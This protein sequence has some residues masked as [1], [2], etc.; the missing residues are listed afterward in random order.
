MVRV[1][2][3]AAYL[4]AAGIVFALAWLPV[5]VTMQ[6]ILYEDFFYALKIADNFIETGEVTF[7]GTARTNA[8]ILQPMWTAL[9]VAARAVAGKELALHIMLTVGAVLHLAQ[10]YLVFSLVA[11]FCNRRVGH[12][13]AVF[14]ALNYRVIACNLCGLEPPL[15]AFFLLLIVWYLR[16]VPRPMTVARS[17]LLGL[18]LAL[19]IMSRFDQVLLAVAVLGLILLDHAAKTRPLRARLISAVT[20]G[21]TMAALLSPWFVWSLRH[22]GTVLPN[23]H[24]ALNLWRFRQF[25]LTGP[26]SEN[27]AVL[28]DKFAEA[29]WW[30][31]D[32]ANLLGVLPLVRPTDV[33]PAV[34]LVL[35]LAVIIMAVLWFSKRGV[36]LSLR[37]ML[38]LYAVIHL[39]YY[40]LFAFPEVRYLVPFGVVGIVLAAS[41]L[42][43]ASMR[44]RGV[45][46]PTTLG[47]VYAVLLTNSLI[48]GF[49]GW[50]KQ[51]GATTTHALHADLHTMA[52][53]VRENTPS[54]AVLGC[55]NA[56]IMGCFSGRTVVNLDGVVNDDVIE[57]MRDKELLRYLRRRGVTHLVDMH[58][59][60]S[61]FMQRFSG[62][63]DWMDHLEPVHHVGRRAVALRLKPFYELD[64][65]RTA[66][67]LP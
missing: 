66:S 39:A 19:A 60:V 29:G 44:A 9:C 56:G 57:A 50:R 55:W 33:R 4:V 31:P 62:R 28:R 63:N 40:C 49:D 2:A 30:L 20:T 34:A 41:L 46:V 17:A 21:G 23:T 24:A 67:L 10:T 12:L 6:H 43:Q 61:K 45:L 26:I 32:T 25:N 3:V 15:Q 48:A 54:D 27:L 58:W 16:R 13:A 8:P 7:D 11:G 1:V 18:L 47:I 35:A 37:R 36:D 59:E 22:S 14:Y 65:T 5:E 51:Q 38:A 64:G 42:G 52:G 53:W